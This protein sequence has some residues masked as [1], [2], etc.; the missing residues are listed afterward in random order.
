MSA[1]SNYK[2]DAINTDHGEEAFDD[3]RELSFLLMLI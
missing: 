3:Y 1:A 2:F